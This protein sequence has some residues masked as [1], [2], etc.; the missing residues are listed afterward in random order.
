MK[1]NHKLFAR[2]AIVMAVLIGALLQS[3]IACAVLLV[4]A[5]LI[6]ARY[7]PRTSG[8]L[9]VTLS[10]PE[11][12]QLIMDAFKTQ[13]PEL[14]GPGGFAT[15]MSSKTAVLGDK[16]TAHIGAV[17]TSADY[18]ATT[19]F[20]NG[21]QDAT[22]LLTDVPVTLNY[23][24]HVPIRVKWL[25]QLSSKLDLTRAVVNQGYALRKLIIDTILQQIT[26]AN[27]THQLPVATVNFNLDSVEALRTKGNTQKMAPMERFGIVST[28]VAGA[29]QGDQR[30]GSSLFYNQ[31]NGNNALRRYT[32]LAGF[33]N[34]YEY[35]DFPTAGNITGFFGD[36]RSVVVAV[37][38]IDYSNAADLLRLPKVMQT[39]PMVDE[40]TGMPFTGVGYQK[41]GTGDAYFT[42]GVLFGVSAGAQGGAADTITDKA[43]IRLVSA[44]NES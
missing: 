27:F 41:Q 26:A 8:C 28:A 10:V 42:V 16:I 23:F 15:D 34:I 22:D 44:G 1:L 21:V 30:V 43:G 25:S 19:G 17:P 35:P 24:K 4:A 29:L 38:A 2:L 9:R 37:R 12:S 7:T 40:E 32:N 6:N 5:A 18:D 14:F 11:L 36:R 39:S 3:F 31:L 13:T 33:Q 20:D